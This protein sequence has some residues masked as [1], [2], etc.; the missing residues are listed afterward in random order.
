MSVFDVQE[1]IIPGQHIREYPHGTRYNQEDVLEIAVK[2]YTPKENVGKDLEG[3][4]TI[5][6]ANGIGFPKVILSSAQK[7]GQ[8]CL[9]AQEVLE[10][11]YEELLHASESNGFKIRA[12][13]A[14]D[15]SCQGLSGVLNE[16]K[17]GDDSML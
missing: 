10:P 4:V 9:F 7:E 13:W 11:L 5:I 6:T 2:K 8:E 3:A 14:A 17:Q 15:W 16:F 12:I 1:H